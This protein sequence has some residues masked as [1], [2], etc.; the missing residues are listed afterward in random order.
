[1]HT[2]KLELP[3]MRNRRSA[4]K[5]IHT[6]APLGARGFKIEKILRRKTNQGSKLKDAFDLVVTYVR[7]TDH[8]DLYYNFGDYGSL[9]DLSRRFPKVQTVNFRW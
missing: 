4:L 3:G 9:E 2:F 6:K 8:P 5:A 1:M 7:P